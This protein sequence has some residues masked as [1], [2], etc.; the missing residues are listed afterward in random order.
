MTHRLARCSGI[1]L[2]VATFIFLAH[3][4]S[5][6]VEETCPPCAVG[7]AMTIY[8]GSNPSDTYR[9]GM[10]VNA[11]EV[12]SPNLLSHWTTIPSAAQCGAKWVWKSDCGI[13]FLP[14]GVG[15]SETFVNGFTIPAGYDVWSACLEISADDKAE[16][17]LNGNYIGIHEDGNGLPS[18]GPWGGPSGG[19]EV[20][21]ISVPSSF[22]HSGIN[23]ANE[24]RITVKSGYLTGGA[25]YSGA[26]WC[27]K[28]CLKMSC[29]CGTS[30]I[31]VEPEAGTA[32]LI[33]SGQIFYARSDSEVHVVWEDPCSSPVCAVGIEWKL[34]DQDSQQPLGD[35]L[36]DC[37][38]GSCHATFIMPN[39]AARFLVPTY[40]CGATLCEGPGF[41]ICPCQCGYWAYG[42]VE[43]PS[44]GTVIPPQ[45]GTLGCVVQ[46]PQQA[47]EICIHSEYLCTKECQGGGDYPPETYLWKVKS[48]IGSQVV[49]EGESPGECKFCVPT[50]DLDGN[51]ASDALIVEIVP[52]CNDHKCAKAHITITFES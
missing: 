9:E 47:G 3:L 45:C 50:V 43:S 33:S 49:A 10:S 34:L 17:E 31:A 41:V 51:G 32:G 38:S 30:Q 21:V 15:N 52:I 26:I 11:T 46:L 2:L 1:F 13:P 23:N 29:S 20:S 8:I 6:A 12:I 16:V 37:T 22:F 42:E 14:P 44:G 18:G 4:V 28:I 5:F 35:G 24:L 19:D 27:L 25:Y 40:S 36:F 39:N 7:T 48:T